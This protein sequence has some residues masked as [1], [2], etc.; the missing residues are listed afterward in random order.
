MKCVHCGYRD[1]CWTSREDDESCK[2]EPVAK[3][4]AG[5]FYKNP[6]EMT[7]SSTWGPA[8]KRDIYGCPSCDKLFMN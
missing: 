4:S 5:D 7:R 8:D 6:V 1:D 3:G 2:D